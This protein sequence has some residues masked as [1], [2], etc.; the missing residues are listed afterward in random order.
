MAYLSKACPRQRPQLSRIER[1]PSDKG[2]QLT[3]ELKTA[4]SEDFTL[5]DSTDQPVSLAQLFSAAPGTAQPKALL[6]VF[7]RGYW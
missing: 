6:L 4:N 7:Y 3:T 2:K 5:P 1:L